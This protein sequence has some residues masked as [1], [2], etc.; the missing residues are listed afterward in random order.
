[1]MHVPARDKEDVARSD[2]DVPVVKH[3]GQDARQPIDRLIEGLVAVR[4][5]HAGRCGDEKLKH[6]QASRGLRSLKKESD[7]DLTRVD[8][9]VSSSRI[10][11]GVPCVIQSSCVFVDAP[12][13]PRSSATP[14][15]AIRSPFLAT[16][17]ASE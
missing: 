10:C 2:T 1:V 8:H 6:R 5:W 9:G 16:R 12:N 3:P 4:D 14:V 13:E 17:C 11:H 7:L 15:D